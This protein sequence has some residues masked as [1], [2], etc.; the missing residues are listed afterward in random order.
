[1][2]FQL[3]ETSIAMTAA[4]TVAAY[5]AVHTCEASSKQTNQLRA[6]YRTLIS[7]TTHTSARA[8]SVMISNSKPFCCVVLFCLVCCVPCAWVCV[9]ALPANWE[10][11]CVSGST[12]PKRWQFNLIEMNCTKNRPNTNSMELSDS[13]IKKCTYIMRCI[14]TMLCSIV[15]SLLCCLHVHFP[16]EFAMFSLAIESYYEKH[17]C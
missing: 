17:L 4:K 11:I 2:C 13:G 15:I 5:Y 12:S 1:M 10:A 16:H 9:A 7:N 14:T 8:R 3:R 6:K